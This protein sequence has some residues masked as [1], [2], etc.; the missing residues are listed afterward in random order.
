MNTSWFSRIRTLDYRYLDA[1]CYGTIGATAYL[2]FIHPAWRFQKL[3]RETEANLKQ[4][5]PRK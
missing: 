3:A 4:V 5:E 2:T 1:F